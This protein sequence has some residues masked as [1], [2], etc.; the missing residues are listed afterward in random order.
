MGRARGMKM[1]SAG[2]IRNMDF[3]TE[4]DRQSCIFIWWTKTESTD[5]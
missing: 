5:W 2:I 1:V 3:D 4:A